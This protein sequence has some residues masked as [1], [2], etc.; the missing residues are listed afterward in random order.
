MEFLALVVLFWLPPV[1]IFFKN[2]LWNLYLWQQKQYRYE[3]F[4]N[5][6]RWDYLPK[7]REISLTVIK[8][9]VFSITCTLI[10]SI[11]S[12]S[13]GVLLAYTIW[14]VEIFLLLEKVFSGKSEKIRLNT[15][16]LGILILLSVLISIAII[17]LTLPFASLQRETG[18]TI[19]PRIENPNAYAIQD[20]YIYL[21]IASI[22]ALF[23]DIAAPVITALAV[24]I[25]SPIGWLKNK[26]AVHKLKD[27]LSKYRNNIIVIAISGSIGKTVTKE[28]IYRMLKD[29]FS[30]VKTSDVYTTVE[31]LSYDIANSINGGTQILLVEIEPF[32]KGEIKEICEVISPDIS[33]ITDIDIQHYG[34]FK[35][36]QEYIESRLELIGGTNH[37]GTVIA[38]IDNK[39]ILHFLNKFPGEKVGFTMLKKKSGKLSE[40]NEV[41]IYKRSVKGYKFMLKNRDS[42]EEYQT[43]I[44][45]SSLINQL[46][47]SI[48]AVKKIGLDKKTTKEKISKLTDKFTSIY[49]LEGDEHSLLISTGN[50]DSN[51]KGVLAAV[52]YANNIM[53]KFKHSRIILITDGVSELGKLKKKS[54]AKLIEKLKHKV[55][56][57]I[58]TDTLLYKLLARSDIELLALN[59]KDTNDTLFTT[60]VILKSGDIVIVEGSDSEEILASLR[61]EE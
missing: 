53:R 50:P 58:T 4:F 28:F 16:S 37:N 20:V 38:P 45:R 14:S 59:T 43:P 17:F 11:Y 18:I 52:D 1:V 57:V 29:E 2:I 44:H 49:T 6:L 51:L 23:I 46:V 55:S 12:S 56:I 30:I 35:N 15:R 7:N 61:S 27:K 40:L 33:I 26:M 54:Y 34:N 22:F 13:I 42:I 41:E 60:R 21:A 10:V 19:T 32:K 48:L 24:L 9:I 31:E 8:Y 47:P 5:Y 36:K 3:R 25:T 39:Y